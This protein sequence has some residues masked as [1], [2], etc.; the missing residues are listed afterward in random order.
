MS[1]S[2][3]KLK[4]N[5]STANTDY[6]II[7]PTT[8]VDPNF[9]VDVM[10][11]VDTTIFGYDYNMTLINPLIQAI[12]V[13][14]LKAWPMARLGLCR[15]TEYPINATNTAYEEIKLLQVVT[16]AQA[17]TWTLVNKGGHSHG[18]TI[19]G[20]GLDALK[21]GCESLTF[22]WRPAAPGRQKIIVLLT[23]KKPADSSETPASPTTTKALARQACIN[24]D[25]WPIWVEFIGGYSPIFN[26]EYGTKLNPFLPSGRYSD[27]IRYDF[28]PDYPEYGG[29]LSFLPGILGGIYNGIV[30]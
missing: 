5:I 19:Y 27:S 8:L 23:N 10:M 20:A 3:S 30:K 12:G 25:V 11:L 22:G 15:F 6:A 1:F 13:N 7:R 17:A 16:E 29:V 2:T 4:T 28:Y 18:T 9:E 21:F 24:N 14:V 26:L